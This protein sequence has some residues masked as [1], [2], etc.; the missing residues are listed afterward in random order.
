VGLLLLLHFYI[1]AV[2]GVSF[3]R[4][5]APEAFGTL[6]RAM[7][8]LFQIVT[9]EGWADILADVLEA[10]PLPPLGTVAYFVSFILL[11]TMIILNLLIGVIM[12]GMQEAQAEAEAAVR[13]R[14]VHDAG[15]P[16]LDDDFRAAER[17]MKELADSLEKLRRRAARGR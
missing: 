17:H 13:A 12:N 8:T 4:A 16:T 10:R 6:P 2:L 1:Y 14:H 9:L 15:A 11:G 3:F 7:L 5:A